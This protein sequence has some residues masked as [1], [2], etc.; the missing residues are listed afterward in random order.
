MAKWGIVLMNLGTPTAPTKAAYRTFLKEFLSDPRVVE[1]PRPIWWPILNLFILPFRPSK[2]VTAY[3]AIWDPESGSPLVSIT[4]RQVE[5]LSKLLAQRHGEEAA[6]VVTY[7]MTYGG[8]K[9]A[10]RVDEL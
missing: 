1:V 8:P 5:A 10:D 6:P 3:E 7:A 4:R 9:L 2:L